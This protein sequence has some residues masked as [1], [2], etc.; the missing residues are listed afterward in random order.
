MYKETVKICVTSPDKLVLLLGRGTECLIPWAPF[1]SSCI[2]NRAD[3][4]MC[5]ASPLSLTALFI[6]TPFCSLEREGAGWGS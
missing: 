6:L 1:S 2:W 4:C 3:V 5:S